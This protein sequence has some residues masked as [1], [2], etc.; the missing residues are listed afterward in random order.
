MQRVYKQ[1]NIAVFGIEFT[2]KTQKPK[3]KGFEFD[4]L[5]Q[6]C[7]LNTRTSEFP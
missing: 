6:Q 5:T 7:M 1:R 2:D 3:N 4:K